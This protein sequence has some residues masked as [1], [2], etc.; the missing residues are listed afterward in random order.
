MNST[1]IVKNESRHPSFFISVHEFATLCQDQAR[2][3]VIAKP[4]TRATI[5]AKFS[6]KIFEIFLIQSP[7]PSMGI[8]ANLNP[9]FEKGG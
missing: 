5:K 2:R 7:P 3:Q 9:P 4:S 1:K 6:S 8:R